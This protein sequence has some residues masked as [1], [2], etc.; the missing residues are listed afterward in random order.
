MAIFVLEAL[1]LDEILEAV[2]AFGVDPRVDPSAV[3]VVVVGT[4]AAEGAVPG[5]VVVVVVEA[6]LE[7]VEAGLG[8]AVEEVVPETVEEEVAETAVVVVEIVV[9][10]VA[11]VGLFTKKEK[12]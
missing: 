8:I 1:D 5:T 11:E 2:E 3:V 10:V 12:K 9:V 6:D 4:V 7:I